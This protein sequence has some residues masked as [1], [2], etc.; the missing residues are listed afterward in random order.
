MLNDAL[1]FVIERTRR[2]VE[3]Q[4]ARV[5][6]ERAGNRD[7]L[8]LASGE[9]RAPLADDR[10]VTL[11]QLENEFVRARK[12]RSRDDALHWH[13]RVGKRDV[14]AHRAVEQHVLLQDDADLTA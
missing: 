7:A 6:R 10:V 3:D 4:D 11:G 5:G 9:R 8:T 1:A 12:R 13:R 14:L 2:L